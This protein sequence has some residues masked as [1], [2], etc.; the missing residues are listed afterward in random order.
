MNPTRCSQHH[1]VER[2]LPPLVINAAI[3][4]YAYY[5]ETKNHHDHN[6]NY[7]DDAELQTLST[8][9]EDSLKSSTN[10]KKHVGFGDVAIS[11]IEHINDCSQEEVAAKWYTDNEYRRMR[12]RCDA[13][14]KMIERG[15]VYNSR[16]VENPNI[17]FRGL[18]SQVIT[19]F[20]F[21]C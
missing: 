19:R 1:D 20:G 5:H 11:P 10:Q 7:D 17:C 15:G 14:V 16:L 8:E 2:I 4:S 21:C 3:F 12:K 18:V 13:T 6:H 9:E